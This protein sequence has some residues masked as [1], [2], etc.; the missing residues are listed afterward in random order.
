MR[1]PNRRSAAG[2]CDF[3][4]RPRLSAYDQPVFWSETADTAVLRLVGGDAPP[5]KGSARLR[6]FLAGDVKATPDDLHILLREIVP[7]LHL[8]ADPSIR[9]DDPLA[10]TVQLDSDGL[11][12]LAALDRLLRNLAGYKVPPDQ[13]MTAQQRRRLKAM[14][15]A[16]DGRQHHASQRE[17]AQILF[18]VDRIADDQWQSSPFRDTVRDLLRDGAAMIAGGYLKLLR[19]RRRP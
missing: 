17:I 3:A 8:V 11:D 18:G 7:G 1:F 15:R 12:R 9:P 5:R 13:R 14:L 16:V 19:F 10:I 4:A 6:A 2:G